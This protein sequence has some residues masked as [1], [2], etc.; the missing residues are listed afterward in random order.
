MPPKIRK[1]KVGA[2]ERETRS[3]ESESPSAVCRGLYHDRDFVWRSLRRRPRFFSFLLL[4]FSLFFSFHTERSH[5]RTNRRGVFSPESGATG[6]RRHEGKGKKEK[7]KERKERKRKKNEIAQSSE[8][9]C[10]GL[11]IIVTIT[12]I[13]L[14]IMRII[15]ND[16]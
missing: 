6:R 1:T 3:A 13:F 12:I 4:F 10:C 9:R 15:I 14:I 2:G 16:M 8:E 7:E 5:V 11:S